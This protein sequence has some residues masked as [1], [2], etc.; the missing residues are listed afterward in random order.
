VN[1]RLIRSTLCLLSMGAL[2]T[3]GA[4]A[5]SHAVSSASDAM[6]K[7]AA[8]YNDGHFRSVIAD[9]ELLRKFN[10]L[11]SQ[12]K[13]IIGQAYYKAGDYAGCAKY[14]REN[15]DISANHTGALL[16]QRCQSLL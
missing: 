2:L 4:I 7:F 3:N 8:D 15:L 11:D 10:V 5:Q 9:G 12:S 14:A 1:L 13:I 6:A 16:L